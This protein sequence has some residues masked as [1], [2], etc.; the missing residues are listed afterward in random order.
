MPGAVEGGRE[1]SLGVRQGA[2]LTITTLVAWSQT[3]R[4]TDGKGA[5]LKLAATDSETNSETSLEANS[6]TPA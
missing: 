1:P 5:Q 4:K 6:M 2:G 3:Q